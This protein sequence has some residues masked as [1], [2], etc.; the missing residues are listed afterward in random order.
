V[1]TEEHAALIRRWWDALN[2]GTAFDLVDEVYAANYVLHDPTSPEP[3][4]GRRGVH[5]F[6]APVLEAF[7]DAHFTVEDLI[8]AGDRIVQRVT[9]RGTHQGELLGV[10]ATGKPVAIWIFVISRMAGGKIAEE[11]QLGDGLSLMRQLG[12]LP[13][14]E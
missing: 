10:E 14:G 3:I 9:L 4:R 1:S 12:V 7:P 6:I 11:W 8:A 2:Q 13:V 5:E